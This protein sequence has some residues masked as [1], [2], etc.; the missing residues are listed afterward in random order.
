MPSGSLAIGAGTARASTLSGSAAHGESRLQVRGGFP[1]IGLRRRPGAQ[2][3]PGFW[4]PAETEQLAYL[5]APPAYQDEGVDASSPPSPDVTWVPGYWAFTN[6]QYA[7]EPGYWGKRFRAGLD[8]PPLCMDSLR[9]RICRGAL[10]SA[11]GRARNAVHSGCVYIAR[12]AATRLC[13]YSGLRPRSWSAGRQSVRES[14]F[15]GLLLRRLLR[16]PISDGGNLSVVCR[17]HG[18]VP[19]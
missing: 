2:R 1:D 10:G 16:R 9:L 6:G 13:L 5:P 12:L 19:V 3:V 4:L 11:D 17:R 14:G 15:S 7:W 18:S 8:C